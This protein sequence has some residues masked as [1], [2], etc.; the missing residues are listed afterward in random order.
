MNSDRVIKRNPVL[1]SI[2]S[3]YDITTSNMIDY[4]TIRNV[5]LGILLISLLFSVFIS[6]H[7]PYN[8]RVVTHISLAIGV[9]G[10]FLFELVIFIKNR[11]NKDD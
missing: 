2:G 9:A 5:F 8:W 1:Y 7:L 4:K 6:D 3:Q 11:L 10:S